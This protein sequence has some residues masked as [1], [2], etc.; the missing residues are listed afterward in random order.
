MSG[1]ATQGTGTR[2]KDR[3]AYPV[4]VVDWTI[5]LETPEGMRVYLC[6]AAKHSTDLVRKTHFEVARWRI[7]SCAGLVVERL[8]EDAG[9]R[10]TAA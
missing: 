4:E 10:E 5:E 3:G 1:R 8:N 7:R 6:G 9:W 2:N